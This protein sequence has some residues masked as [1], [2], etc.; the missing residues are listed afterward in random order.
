MF[1]FTGSIN[2]AF[3]FLE[4]F[5]ITYCTLN[6]WRDN[7]NNVI[8]IKPTFTRFVFDSVINVIEDKQ[9]YFL[10]YNT[11]LCARNHQA[12]KV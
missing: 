9:S 2:S 8:K 5:A 3:S 10:F 1:V 11:I 12:I 7:I 6:K 4:L